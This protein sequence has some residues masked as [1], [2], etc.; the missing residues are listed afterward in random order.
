[1]PTKSVEYAAQKALEA[2]RGALEFRSDTSEAL[3]QAI[4]FVEKDS[5]LGQLCQ[6]IL[7]AKPPIMNATD[8]DMEMAEL[9][10]DEMREHAVT[11]SEAMLDE[12]TA[13]LAA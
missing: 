2:A 10:C 6:A 9:A 3:L 13:L 7:T 12:I 8:H 1:M 11:L 5:D 4:V